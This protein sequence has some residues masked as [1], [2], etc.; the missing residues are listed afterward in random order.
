VKGAGVAFYL[1]GYSGEKTL[2][3][4]AVTGEDGKFVLSTY[5]MNDGAPAGNYRVTVRVPS[6]PGPL[7]K[8]P[9]KLKG[10]YARPDTSGLTARVEK[11]KNQLPP[12]DLQANPDEPK[13]KT[14]TMK[15][16][17][18]EWTVPLP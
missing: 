3:P 14:K 13:P 12:F 11:G 5:A 8:S 10:K 6:G 1:D 15:K 2:L 16:G 18:H 9:D 4:M 7:V 17:V